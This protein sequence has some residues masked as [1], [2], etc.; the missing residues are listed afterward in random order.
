MKTKHASD[1]EM[2]AKNQ[3]ELTSDLT[4]TKHQ[5]LDVQHQLSMAEKVKTRIKTRVVLHGTHR[6]HAFSL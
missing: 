6:I 1:Q 2:N 4:T 3:Q 5:L